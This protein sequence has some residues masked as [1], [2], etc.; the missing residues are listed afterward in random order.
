MPCCRSSHRIAVR[1]MPESSSVWALMISN[2]SWRISV[3]SLPPPGPFF[4]FAGNAASME[5]FPAWASFSSKAPAFPPPPEAMTVREAVRLFTKDAAYASYT[6]DV[7]GTIEIG[8]YADLAVLD[9]NL[10]EISPDAIKDVQVEMT[11]LNG[12]VVYEK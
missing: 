6:E 3:F 11:I 10:Y 1:P 4:L 8:K 12:K 2:T 9:Q 5:L 7:N